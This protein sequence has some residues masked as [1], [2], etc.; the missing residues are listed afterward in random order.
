MKLAA[1]LLTGLWA[2]TAN[3]GGVLAH[4]SSEA[5]RTSP[6]FTPSASRGQTLFQR[7][8]TTSAG[9]PRCTICH[10]NNPRNPGR[11]AITGKTIQPMQPAV[12]PTRLSDLVKTE[13]W[14]RRNCREVVGREC[15][16]SEKA[17]VVTFLLQ[18]TQS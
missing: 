13:K 17:D 14:F 5:A 6:G 16:A 18:G 1:V 12:E 2:C 15:S 11:H 3:A 8:W 7:T 10:G 4:Y 9:L